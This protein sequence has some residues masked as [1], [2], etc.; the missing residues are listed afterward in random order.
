MNWKVAVQFFGL[1]CL[2]L[3]SD[4]LLKAYVY[5]NIPPM[6]RG[7]FLYPYGGIGVMHNWHG[8]EFSLVH[9]QNLGAVCGLFSGFHT[10][11]L[12]A[13]VAIVAGLVGY[14]V[15]VKNSPLIKFSF[16]LICVG[17]LGNII[18]HFIYGHV[19]DMF[20]FVFWRFSYPVFNIADVSISC[21]IGLLLFQ[22]LWRKER[23]GVSV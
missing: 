22:K 18:D 1:A 6:Q 16:T 7:F 2:I 4:V 11:L 19:I 3:L 5:A 21:G 8:I 12:Y 13:R 10:A 23:S 17:A 20:Y 15:F 9:V 14:L